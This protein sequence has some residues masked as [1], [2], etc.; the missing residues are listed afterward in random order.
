V[1]TPRVTWVGVV[2]ITEGLTDM[3]ILLQVGHITIKTQI[4]RF[5]HV[6]N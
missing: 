4:K 6:K 2:R 1:A 3:E 5:L